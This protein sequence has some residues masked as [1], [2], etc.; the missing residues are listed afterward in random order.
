MLALAALITGA[1][2]GLFPV[3]TQAQKTEWNDARTLVLVQ[4]AVDR[5]SRQFASGLTD[6]TAAARGYLTFLGQFG[7]GFPEPPRVVKVDQ[8][9]VQLFWKAPMLS[10]QRLIGQRDTL[11]LPA[12]IGYYRDRF[13]IVQNNFPNLIRMGDG[14]D[15]RDVPHPLS[16]RG[17]ATY[18]FAIR[19]SLILEYPDRV[20]SVYVVHVRPRDDSQ[21]A[22]IGAVYLDRDSGA[23]ARM[24]R[25]LVG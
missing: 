7:E 14:R 22:V 3:A 11:L 19:D 4:R 5:R 10:K 15:V 1:L 18:D 8:L 16:E 6:Y 23:V 21:P 13:G 24:A 17:L 12:E 2:F 20:L 9:A 25:P